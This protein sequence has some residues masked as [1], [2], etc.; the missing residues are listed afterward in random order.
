MKRIILALALVLG[1]ASCAM[2]EKLQCKSAMGTA[3]TVEV[4]Q[5][6]ITKQMQGGCTLLKQDGSEAIS[7]AYFPASGANAKAFAMELAK[8]MNVKPT[9]NAQK[10]DYV[11]FDAV[12]NGQKLNVSVTGKADDSELQV[13]TQKGESDTLEQIFDSVTF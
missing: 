10:D 2:A 7:I 6:W 11:D 1:L 4:P 3:F 12:L 13:V 5:G 9:F 8:K